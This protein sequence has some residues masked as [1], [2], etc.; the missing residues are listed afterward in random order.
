MFSQNY[1]LLSSQYSSDIWLL[2]VI[3]HLLVR[4][5]FC[6]VYFA[7]IW[8]FSHSQLRTR[9]TPERR[10]T[11][12][13]AS[14]CFVYCL[15]NS[16]VLFMNPDNNSLPFFHMALPN[17]NKRNVVFVCANAELLSH[18]QH[19]FTC[20]HGY[21]IPF[22]SIGYQREYPRAVNRRR[23]EVRNKEE[24]YI[25]SVFA[26]LLATLDVRGKFRHRRLQRLSCQP[27]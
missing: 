9:Y 2:L 1:L 17:R 11:T 21:R 6:F 15:N 3:T 14:S 10:P 5:H 4:Q 13:C 7:S 16:Q 23:P 18:A 8:S 20:A 26:Y 24:E 12:T 19:K 22:I 25:L 27:L